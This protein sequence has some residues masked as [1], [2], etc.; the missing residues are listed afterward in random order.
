MRLIKINQKK[1]EKSSLSRSRSERRLK[2]TLSVNQVFKQ[3]G[4]V[5]GRIRVDF[6]RAVSDTI[7]VE[8]QLAGR[9]MKTAPRL[10]SGESGTGQRVARGVEPAE[11][12]AQRFDF[13]GRQRAAGQFGSEVAADHAPFAEERESDYAEQ[14]EECGDHEQKI[15]AE[16]QEHLGLH[17]LFLLFGEV[18]ARIG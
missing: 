18:L 4:F 16:H 7:A 13:A 11:D 3:F 14:A 12:A 6:D 17:F 8:G 15:G 9:F 10:P 5:C 2:P 1:C